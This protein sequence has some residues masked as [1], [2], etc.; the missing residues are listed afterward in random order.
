MNFN[1]VAIGNFYSGLYYE[2]DEE[3]ET[4]G[5]PKKMKFKPHGDTP[6]REARNQP[7]S[8]ALGSKFSASIKVYESYNFK[9][10]DKVE[11]PEFNIKAEI[12]AVDPVIGVTTALANMFIKGGSGYTPKILHLNKDDL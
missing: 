2:F 8:G 10:K 11:L 3:S 5:N 12:T 1:F 6:I 7:I 4:Y 9:P